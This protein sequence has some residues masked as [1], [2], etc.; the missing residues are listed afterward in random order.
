MLYRLYRLLSW[1]MLKLFF[2][3]IEVEGRS[4]VPAAG[5]LLLVP[6]HSNALVDP[7]VLIVTLR[8]RLTLT[9]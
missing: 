3:R 2:R 9:A 8:R 5:P 7:L 6:N 4:Q 1:V